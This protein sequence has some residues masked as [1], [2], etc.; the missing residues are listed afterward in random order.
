MKFPGRQ[1]IAVSKKFGFTKYYKSEYYKLQ[2][3][4]KIIPDG[5]NVKV[6][7]PHGPL[8]RLALFK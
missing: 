6:I 1:T 2:K 5:I 8:S 4:G 3:E 7:T